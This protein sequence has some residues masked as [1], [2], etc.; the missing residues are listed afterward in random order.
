MYGTCSLISLNEKIRYHFDAS[1]RQALHPTVAGYC[2]VHE[3][4]DDHSGSVRM[5]YIY[6]FIIMQQYT[7]L[8]T[9]VKQASTWQCQ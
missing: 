6:K 7:W 3:V 4:L 5:I 1:I 9:I 2:R 8:F